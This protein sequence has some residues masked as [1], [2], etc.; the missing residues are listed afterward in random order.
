MTWFSS[1]KLVEYRPNSRMESHAHEQPSLSLIVD[2]RYDEQVQGTTAQHGPG[3]MLYCPAGVE[4]AQS[5]LGAGAW[6]AL[7]TPA[8]DCL[9][10]LSEGVDLA[11]PSFQASEQFATLGRRMAAELRRNDRFSSLALEAL[12]LEAATVFARATC[13][14]DRPPKW[15][16]RVLDYVRDHAGQALTIDDVARAV[17]CRPEDIGPALK[18]HHRVSLAG[19]ARRCRLEAVARMLVADELPISAIAVDCGFCDQAHLT[20]AFKSVY[21]ITPGAFRRMKPATTLLT[22][23]R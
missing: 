12:A 2:G 13:S 11:D 8:N 23:G 10:A 17:E 18:A 7:I 16:P 19:L 22:K 20:R 1:I 21:G 3:H 14:H 6:Q 9:D 15:L 4:H 5:F